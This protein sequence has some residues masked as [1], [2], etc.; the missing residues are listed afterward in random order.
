MFK[1]CVIVFFLFV[2]LILS[3]N[4]ENESV[5]K[6][7]S[8]QEINS[9][10]ITVLNN[11]GI[12]G[13]YPGQFELD[14]FE[15]LTGIQLSF[16]GNPLFDQNLA[17]RLPDEPLVVMPY[18][19]PGSYGGI[20]RGVSRAPESGTSGV[21][22]WRHANLLR[23]S[24]DF[25]TI[26]PNIAKSWEF[27][28]ENT[29]LTFH[30]RKGHKWSDGEPFTSEDILFW[31]KD[32]QLNKA[33]KK[34]VKDTWVFSG[35][36]MDVRVV[37]DYTVEFLFPVPAP[38]AVL[39]FAT[40]Y[41][42]P[43][44][45]KHFLKQFHADYNPQ[46]NEQAKELG[47]EDW[48]T[49]FYVYYHDWKDS[50]HPLS[51]KK[52]M[53]TPTLETHTLIEETT[54]YRRLQANPY[55][56]E[57]D[58]LGNQLPYTNEI[59]EVF[60]QDREV[61]NLKLM[62]GE[63]D[64]KAQGMMLIDYPL[65]K[66]NEDSGDYKVVLAP[67]GTSSMVMLGL[68]ITHKDPA[69]REIFSD[70]RFKKA[71]SVALNRD[72]INE[73]CYMGQGVPM[74]V[75]PGEHNTVNFISQE[76]RNYMIDYD[77]ARANAL[78]D[79][80]GLKKGQDGFRRRKDGKP[81]TVFIQYTTQGSSDSLMQLVEEYWEAVGVRTELKEVSSDLYWHLVDNNDHDV[82]VWV[83]NG[84]TPPALFSDPPFIPPFEDVAVGKPWDAW[85][86]TNGATGEEPPAYIKKLYELAEL[87]RMQ[88]YDSAEYNRIGAEMA[89]IH[90]DKL[91][92]I[93]TVGDVGNPVF[94]NNRLHNVPEIRYSSYDYYYA[95]PFRASQWFIKE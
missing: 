48:I 67:T 26:I 89:E 10:A 47:Y 12:V 52:P 16:Q 74:Q 56:H 57:V 31:W 76:M 49:L 87:F 69:M 51:G 55:Y 34:N 18:R 13:K 53:N 7:G 4:G 43:F 77:P 68:N 75:T 38:G 81:L 91:L 40:K 59:Y 35:E 23:F 54:E 66:E 88:E 71:M 3:A 83:G 2:P 45:P 28:E 60:I 5:S 29:K 65:L 27:N 6:S 37:D 41:I 19:Q 22:S 15:S 32:I 24:D 92:R 39:V 30:L 50:Y 64:F 11:Q 94:I 44:Q 61:A 25:K 46:A 72:E 70:I 33:L 84:N 85:T 93:G 86:T 95:Y 21:L 36:P 1:K 79:E 20:L 58:T 78:L 62:N 90:L 73:I 8:A 42:S 9:D 82:G 63:I 17:D 80:M 14:E